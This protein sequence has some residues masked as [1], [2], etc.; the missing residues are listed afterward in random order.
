MR[1][2]KT[3]HTITYITKFQE[4]VNIT[5]V[6]FRQVS[7]A[8]SSI[9]WNVGCIIPVNMAS[10]KHLLCS[11][12]IAQKNTSHLVWNK[13]FPIFYSAHIENN[14]FVPNF[15]CIFIGCPSIN[16]RSLSKSWSLSQWWYLHFHRRRTNLWV[17]LYWLWWI[18]LWT[19]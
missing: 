9:L 4:K 14:Y 18:L 19:K 5:N 2:I 17:Q 10:F 11:S 16:C 6:Y 15:V 8:D 1:R 7:Q 3:P 12:Q 13:I